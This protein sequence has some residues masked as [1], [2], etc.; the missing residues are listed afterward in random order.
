VPF[1]FL[2]HQ[3]PVVPLKLARPGWF[4]G[5][6]LAVGSTAPDLAYA[7][8]GTRAAVDGHTL[9]AQLWLCLP[10]TL[11]IVWLVRRVVA[12]PLA[13]HMPDAEP[14]RLR[15]YRLLAA[16]RHPLGITVASA[17]TGSLSHVAIDAWTHRDGWVVARAGLLR[18]EVLTVGG[19]PVAVFKLLQY[20]GHVGGVALGVW[21]LWLLGRRRL[22]RRW[23]PA[24]PPLLVATVASRVRLWAPVAAAGVLAVVT[25][26]LGLA[27]G[28]PAAVVR[29]ALVL[30]A[31]VTAGCLLARPWMEKGPRATARDAGVPRP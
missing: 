1:T 27:D 16:G 28:V 20:A 4:D 12:A 9:A 23:N 7:L 22:L 19:T 10:V 14:W 31:G 25:G 2:S 3:V 30:L 6:A 15:D 13:A 18:T 24:V 29:S 26:V 8:N 11:A 5:T 21:L 17:L